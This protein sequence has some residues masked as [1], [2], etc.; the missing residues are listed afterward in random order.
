MT[1][2][3]PRT[4]Q[5]S[6]C[7]AHWAPGAPLL[8]P[9]EVDMG[10][11]RGKQ[12]RGIETQAA[13]IEASGR[14][15]SRMEY[16]KAKLKDISEE[17]G[18]SLGSLY[19]HFGN[20]DD[21]AMAVLDTQQER[22]DAVLTRVAEE[23][24]PD[25]LARLWALLDG[26]ADLIATDTMVQAGIRLVS[27]LPEELRDRGYGDVEGWQRMTRTLITEGIADGSI[28]STRSADALTELIDEVFVGA[29]VMADMQDGGVSLP[30]RIVRARPLLHLLLAPDSPA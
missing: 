5:E 13:L 20:K 9:G 16:D 22:M 19:F 21:V 26:V 30:A 6:Q 10:E 23:P 17:A 28:T 7:G 14:V 18:I 15:F 25:A 2:G 4:V 29:Q 11:S 12:Q 24:H 8:T 1:G 3:L 27:S